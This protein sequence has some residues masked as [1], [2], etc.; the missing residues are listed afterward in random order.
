[1]HIARVEL[2]KAGSVKASLRA[3]SQSRA[4][5]E[6]PHMLQLAVVHFDI[7]SIASTVGHFM[8]VLCHGA[9]ISG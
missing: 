2:L 7:A 5:S 4:F 8:Q 9:A 6:R 1:M 3:R